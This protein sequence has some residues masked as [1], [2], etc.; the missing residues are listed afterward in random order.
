MVKGERYGNNNGSSSR[1]RDKS[2]A[3]N[4]NGNRIY[5]R[6]FIGEAKMIAISKP[7]GTK[8]YYCKVCKRIIWVQPM[9]V[10]RCP[11]CGNEV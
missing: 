5:Y 9:T 2:F 7:V 6:L 8:P 1:D 3:D 11:I 4:R 10:T